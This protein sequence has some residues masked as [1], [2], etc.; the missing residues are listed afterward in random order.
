[1]RHLIVT[2]RLTLRD[3]RKSNLLPKAQTEAHNIKHKNKEA[4]GT[5]INYSKRKESGA[6][7]NKPWTEANS[8]KR[9]QTEG[10]DSKKEQ[11]PI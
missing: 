11:N 4:N 10:N 1:M 6:N 7:P 5:N 8:S 2:T 9:H 3:F